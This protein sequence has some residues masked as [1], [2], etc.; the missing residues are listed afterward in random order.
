[1]YLDYV[2]CFV[3]GSY[4]LLLVMLGSIK[5]IEGFDLGGVLKQFTIMHALFICTVFSSSPLSCMCT[6]QASGELQLLK[7]Y[8]PLMSIYKL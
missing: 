3:I 2:E 7:S 4:V 5:L 6:A 1:M 8:R